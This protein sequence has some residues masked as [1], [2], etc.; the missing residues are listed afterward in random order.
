MKYRIVCRS[1]IFISNK[2]IIQRKRLFI[3]K[4]IPMYFNHYLDAEHIINKLKAGDSYIIIQRVLIKRGIK[5]YEYGEPKEIT[6]KDKY[7]VNRN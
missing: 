5:E 2:Y 4:D 7:H 1:D 6:I 3:W